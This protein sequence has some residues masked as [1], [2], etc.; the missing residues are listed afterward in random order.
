M[1]LCLNKKI[2]QKSFANVLDIPCMGYEMILFVG[3]NAYTKQL[4]L[5]SNV[6][7]HRLIRYRYSV[8]RIG[9]NTYRSNRGQPCTQ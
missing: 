7:K 9:W 2:I 8:I 5:D 3:N 6:N 4:G 1:R